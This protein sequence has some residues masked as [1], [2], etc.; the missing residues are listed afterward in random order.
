MV[1]SENP[2][3]ILIVDDHLVVREGLAR[4]IGSDPGMQLVGEAANGEEAISQW[5]KLQPDV[6]LLDM[7]MR[8][9]G[10]IQ[11]LEEI[12]KRFPS[13]RILILSSYDH[14]E[15]IYRA[16]QAGALGYLLKDSSRKQLLN[17]IRRVHAGERCIPHAVA[18]QLAQRIASNELT[19]REQEILEKIVEGKSNKEIGDL[20]GISEGTVKSHVNKILEKLQVTDR[21]Q[22][23]VLAL[24]KGL[25]RMK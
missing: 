23:V 17:S 11:T 6:T 16:L 14:E 22:A 12:R 3:K 7:R 8:G 2:I 21:T 24:K 13:A 9:M 10:G 1:E 4:I 18:G 15:D 25:A 19:P 5:E 20:L